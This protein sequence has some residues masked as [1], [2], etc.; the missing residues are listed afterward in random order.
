[1]NTSSPNSAAGT[2]G[3][4]PTVVLVHGAFADSSSW[5]TVVA[6]LRESGHPVIAAANPLR[7]L[8]DDAAYVRDVL[9]AVDGPVILVGHSYGGAVI[10]TAAEGASNVRALVYIAA[11][12]PEAGES[13]ADLAGKFPGS[14]LGEALREVSLTSPD[15]SAVV[16]LYIEQE[17]FHGQFAADVAPDKAAV[18]A[19]TQRPITASALSDKAAVAAWQNL[20]V[21]SL[22]AT[23]DRNIPAQAQVFMGERAG[24]RTISV[25]ASHAAAVSHPEAVVQLVEEAAQATA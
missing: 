1:M 15:G 18:M 7:G 9:A 24:A 25:A 23:E 17:K 20:P 4:K 19:A 12:L 16:D 22:I 6:R 14:T 10:S 13:A 2:P 5:N 3:T 8:A 21:W 11:F